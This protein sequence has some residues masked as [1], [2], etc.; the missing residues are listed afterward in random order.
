VASGNIQDTNAEENGDTGLLLPVQF[1][2]PNDSLG[3]QEHGNIRHNLDTCR[4][5]HHIRQAVAFAREIEFPNGCV[6]AALH[7]QKNDAKKSPDSLKGYD[8]CA[9]PP[10]SISGFFDGD[11]NT[12]PVHQDG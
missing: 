10:E 2:A 3:Q 6:R 5:E 7:V 12:A 4:G 9:A 1:Q 11:K 8:G